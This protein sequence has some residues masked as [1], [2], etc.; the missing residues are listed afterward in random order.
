MR[1][2]MLCVFVG[3]LALTPL[4]LFHNFIMPELAMLDEAYRS[5]DQTAAQIASQQ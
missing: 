4:F 2:L 5:A 3:V 1:L